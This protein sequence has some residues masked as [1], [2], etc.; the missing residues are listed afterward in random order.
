MN[1]ERVV[2]E[3]PREMGQWLETHGST[4][5]WRAVARDVALNVA[6]ALLL[7]DGEAGVNPV[8]YDLLGKHPS[9]AVRVLTQTAEFKHR[10]WYAHWIIPKVADWFGLSPTWL[11]AQLRGARQKPLRKTLGEL[12]PHPGDGSCVEPASSGEGVSIHPTRTGSF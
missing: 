8:E 12:S 2:A 9:P 6:E 10:R 5:T 1:R 4:R 7:H 11:Y 3:L